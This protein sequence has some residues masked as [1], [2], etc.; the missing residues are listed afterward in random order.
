MLTVSV[1]VLVVESQLAARAL[2]CPCGGVLAPWGHA[3]CRVVIDVG[4]DRRV[5]PRRARCRSCR[6][7][8]VLLP[9][10]VLVRRGYT[11]AVI[12]RVLEWAAAGMAVRRLAG[13]AELPR[14]TVRGWLARF[15]AL[16]EVLAGHFLAWLLWL[17]PSRARLGSSRQATAVADTVAAVVAAGQAGSGV[18][19]GQGVWAFASAATGGRLLCNTTAPFPAP[20]TR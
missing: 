18:V 3:R 12:G 7:T 11:A 17:A 8:H 9:A 13:L 5:Q 6:Q 20:W 19:D 14:S 16:A 10:I 4:E 1:D 15:S 2:S